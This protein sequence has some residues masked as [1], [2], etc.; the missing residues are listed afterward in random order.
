MAYSLRNICTKNY[1]TRTTSVKIIVG[2]G[3]VYFVETQCSM[4]GVI[5]I[6]ELS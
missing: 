5:P 4:N 6:N 3:V 1:W 2:G